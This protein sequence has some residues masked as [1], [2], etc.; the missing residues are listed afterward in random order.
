MPDYY[1]NI[2]LTPLRIFVQSDGAS[3]VTSSIS[4]SNSTA[5]QSTILSKRDE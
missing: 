4:Q 1:D 3:F 2:A 5:Q